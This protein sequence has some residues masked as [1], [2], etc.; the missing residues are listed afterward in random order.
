VTEP[1]PTAAPSTLRWAVL[2]LAAEAVA[3]AA[4]AVW[5]G[6]AAAGDAGQ[7]TASRVATPAFALLL[8]VILGGLARALHRRYAG[9][10]GPAVVL[11]LLLV[12]IG[13][14][15]VGGGLPW[16]GVLEL[17]AGIAGVILLLAPSTRAGL[18]VE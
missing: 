8:A 1:T 5:A 2:L 3:V 4:V 16:L 18:G 14:Y 6:V 15:T 11:Q 9:A 10:R 12:P 17:L 7:S 13:W